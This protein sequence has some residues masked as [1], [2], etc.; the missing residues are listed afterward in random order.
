LNKSQHI[1]KLKQIKREEL[2]YDQKHTGSRYLLYYEAIP[3][4]MAY[5]KTQENPQTVA[6]HRLEK[7][8][9]EVAD[10]LI[11]FNILCEVTPHLCG[12]NEQG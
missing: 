8:L 1:I 7:I 6:S 2:G 12:F 10:D 4:S 11:E 5:V 3:Y 9:K